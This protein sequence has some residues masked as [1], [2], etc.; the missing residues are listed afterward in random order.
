MNSGGGQ[1]MKFKAIL[2]D[3]YGTLFDVHTVIETCEEYYPDKGTKISQLWR[4]KQIEYA[5]QSQIM[6]RY[7]DFYELTKKS[8][9]YAVDV[10]DEGIT[11]GSEEAL[12]HAYSRLNL[13]SEVKQVLAY[14]KE[15][16]YLL[17]IFTNGPKHMIDPLVAHH[18]LAPLFDD[19]ISVDE[20]KQFKPAMASYHYAANKLEV[21]RDEVL[22]LSSNP[23]DIA[24]AKNYG[25]STVWVNRHQQVPEHRELT[26]NRVI[27]DLT[28]LVK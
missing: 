26:P 12:L 6:G 8:L 1:I 27:H 17:A 19:V 10:V 28:N 15:K 11:P 3:A 20:I 2:F 21:E 22:F 13:Y 16:G 25:F 14:L 23:W 24:G 18:K 5:M 4:Q 9:R 7:V